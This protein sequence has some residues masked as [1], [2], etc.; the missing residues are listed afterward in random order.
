[1]R[2]LVLP[3]VPGAGHRRQWKPSGEVE[4]MATVR[5]G[6]LSA[7]VGDRTA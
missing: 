6:Q 2:E 3:L 1:M 5:R 4:L 7:Y